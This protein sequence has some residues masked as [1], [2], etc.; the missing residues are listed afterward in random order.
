MCAVKTRPKAAPGPLRSV[1]S[2]VGHG[3]A[4]PEPVFGEVR[5]SVVAAAVAEVQVRP[6]TGGVQLELVPPPPSSYTECCT[7]GARRTYQPDELSRA[8]LLIFTD[9]MRWHDVEPDDVASFRVDSEDET[10]TL[11]MHDGVVRVLPLQS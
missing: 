5:G 10:L 6:Q 8:Q 9:W 11:V 3:S 4:G 7:Q 1:T 2:R